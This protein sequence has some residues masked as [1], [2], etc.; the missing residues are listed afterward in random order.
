MSH[1]T[2]YPGGK[3]KLDEIDLQILKELQYNGRITN[4]ELAR[5]AGITAP[6]CLRRLRAL[7]EAGYIRGYHADVPGELLGFSVTTFAYVALVSQKDTDLQAF[8]QRVATWPEVRECHMLAGDTDYLLKVVTRDWQAYHQFLN[9]KLLPAHNVAQVRSSLAV[10]N[11]KTLPG[12]P[13][14]TL[15]EPESVHAA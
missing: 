9:E 15:A 8:E 3:Y 10:R 12:I 5:R 14:E 6:P 2:F 1:S 13:L 7:E 4:V 11:S